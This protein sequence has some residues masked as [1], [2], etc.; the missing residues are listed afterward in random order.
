MNRQFTLKIDIED[1]FASV[2]SSVG[3]KENF[4][5]FGLPSS[6]NE[7]VS[8]LVKANLKQEGG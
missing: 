7:G 6:V 8:L 3:G 4:E 2:I 1:D 5:W